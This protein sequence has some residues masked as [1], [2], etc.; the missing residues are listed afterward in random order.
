MSQ[1]FEEDDRIGTLHP[2]FVIP[3]GTAEEM[4]AYFASKGGF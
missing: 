2:V 4:R 1:I 3:E